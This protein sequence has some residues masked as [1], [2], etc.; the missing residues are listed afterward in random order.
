MRAIELLENL[1]EHA[2]KFRLDHD[3]YKRNAHIHGKID[4]PSQEVID[5]IL[6]GFI[7]DIGISN[8][9]GY[10]LYVSDLKKNGKL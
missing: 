2:K 4:I 5:A 1:T 7:N 6:V 3:Y 8:G 10:A 9:I